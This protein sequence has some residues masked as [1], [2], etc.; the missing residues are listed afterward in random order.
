VYDLT[1]KKIKIINNIYLFGETVE[2]CL[3]GGISGGVFVDA[4]NGVGWYKY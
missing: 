2:L 4:M 3:R 1:I